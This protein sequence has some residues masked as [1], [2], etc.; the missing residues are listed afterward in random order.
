MSPSVLTIMLRYLDTRGVLMETL[1]ANAI[2]QLPI[3]AVTTVE[4]CNQHGTLETSKVEDWKL[5]APNIWLVM[6]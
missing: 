3:G 5:V 1:F 4:V 6:S 2:D